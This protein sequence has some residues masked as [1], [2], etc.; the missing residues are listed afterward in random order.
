MAKPKTPVKL[1]AAVVRKA[2]LYL[3]DPEVE[4]EDTMATAAGLAVHLGVPSTRLRDW[5]SQDGDLADR[6]REIMTRIEDNIERLLIDKGLRG[7]WA[8]SLVKHIM[9]TKHGYVEQQEVKME[10]SVKDMAAKI[11]KENAEDMYME[12]MGQAE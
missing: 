11:T 5:V 4:A 2:A 6:F 10:V 12:I 1:T 3:E 8:P 7:D 9:A